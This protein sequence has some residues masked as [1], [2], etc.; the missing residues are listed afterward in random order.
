MTNY[1]FLNVH[2]ITFLIL[3]NYIVYFFTIVFLSDAF[4]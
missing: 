3:N 1:M 4:I 2:M